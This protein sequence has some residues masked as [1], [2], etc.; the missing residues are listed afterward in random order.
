MRYLSMTPTKG[1][2]FAS[3]ALLLVADTASAQIF[4]GRRSRGMDQ[5]YYQGNQGY[6]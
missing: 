5:G 2:L 6:N 3:L 1:L 4:R